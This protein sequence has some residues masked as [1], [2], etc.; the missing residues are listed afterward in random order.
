MRYPTGTTDQYIYFVAVDAT[1]LKTRE[2][3]LG[4]F[5]VVR[6]RNGAADVTYTTPTV[7][8]VDAV[9]MPGVYTLL[10]DEDMTIGAGN[11]SEQVCLHIT[12]ASMAPVTLVYELYRRDTT[13]G[14]TLTVG[15]GIASADVVEW[16]GTAPATPTVAGVPEVD[17]THWIGTA[18]ATPTTAGVPEVDVTYWLGTAA[19]TPTVAGVPEVDVTHWIGTA[20]ATPTVAGVPEVD[21][22]YVNG[23][24][25]AS[26][27]SR[28][29]NSMV[30]GTADSGST[31][32]MVDAALT[33]AD[34]DY[35]KGNIIAFT[36]GTLAKQAR[37]IT[38]FNPA[39][40]T[41]TF[42]PALTQAVSTHT[43]VIFPAGLSDLWGVNGVATTAT[44][45][46]IKTE[47]ATIVADTNELQTD[48]ANGGRLD[49][50]IDSVLVDTAEIGAAGAGLTNINLPDQTMNITGDI[51]GNLSGSVG[52]VTGNVGGNV[53]GSVG[54]LAVQAKSDVNAEVVDAINVDSYGE[55]TG[56]PAASASLATKISNLYMVLRNKVTVTDS[57]LTVYDDGDAAEW[58]KDLS[59]DG[60]TYTESEA[61]A[62]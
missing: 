44:L 3:G 23:S 45:D 53:T 46:T 21:V 32:T 11:D 60:S 2:T 12:Q 7:A 29:I 50:I 5:T 47:T 18:A 56:V 28:W 9:T 42:A 27:L 24:A 62:I 8:E 54:S 19:A 40:D 61:N 13:G 34:T 51:T 17:V 14:E 10:L 39:T 55:P 43:Y 6:S 15:S 31:T 48:W 25:D 37:L 20:A 4:T 59:D 57:K 58:E 33:Q 1:D 16:L 26:I 52:S 30:I 41:V 22:T 49:L 36:N 38:G 35:F